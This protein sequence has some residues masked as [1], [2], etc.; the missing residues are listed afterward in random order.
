MRFS[1]D[2][3]QERLDE[4]IDLARAGN[5]VVLVGEAGELV[6]LVPIASPTSLTR[7]WKHA[8]LEE[9]MQQGSRRASSGPS[10]ARSQDFLYNDE[11]GLPE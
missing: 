11:T 5:E 10:A 3:A 1:I 9:V 6:Q 8:L 4:L 7:E 2:E